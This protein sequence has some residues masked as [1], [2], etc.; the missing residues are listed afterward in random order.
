MTAV[1]GDH[2]IV[3]VPRRQVGVAIVPVVKP[4]PELGGALGEDREQR[5]SSDPDKSVPRRARPPTRDADFDVV[6]LR[7]SRGDGFARNRVI[8][9]Q[10]LDRLVGEHHPPAEGHARGVAL[11]QVDLGLRLAAA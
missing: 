3:A 10:P 7:E 5:L 6:P 9:Q 4:H 8:G 1:G 2:E 11:E